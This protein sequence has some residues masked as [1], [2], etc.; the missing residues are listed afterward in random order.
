MFLLRTMEIVLYIVLSIVILVL[1]IT[2]FFVVKAI[3]KN[4][5]LENRKK[6]NNELILALGGKENIVNVQ[7]RGSRLTLVLKDY[8]VVNEEKLKM[9]GVSSIIKMSEK[10]TLVIGQESKELES[11]INL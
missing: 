10:I 2:L 6:S 11:L 9:H 8:E 7:A 4:K 5:F 1:G 3:R